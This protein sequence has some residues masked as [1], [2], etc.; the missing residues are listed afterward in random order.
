MLAIVGM[1]GFCLMQELKSGS[2]AEVDI[3]TNTN[4]TGVEYWNGQFIVCGFDGYLC[5][6]NGDEWSVVEVELEVGDFWGVSTFDGRLFVLSDAM[7]LPL[8]MGCRGNLSGCACG[9][10]LSSVSTPCPSSC[11]SR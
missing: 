8:P 2:W 11:D 3:G 4:L 5:K 1:D 7:V 9:G 10:Q 6:G